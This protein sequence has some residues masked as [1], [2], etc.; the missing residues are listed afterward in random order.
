MTYLQ[1][2][3]LENEI[4]KL[5]EQKKYLEE[6]VDVQIFDLNYPNTIFK[7][8][9]IRRIADIIELKRLFFNKVKMQGMH[10]LYTGFLSLQ[11]RK[12]IAKIRENEHSAYLPEFN[13]DYSKI[14]FRKSS[15]V[16]KEEYLKNTDFINDVLPNGGIIYVLSYKGAKFINSINN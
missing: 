3:N 5:N 13:N 1:Y 15:P 7:T 14:V 12:N 4:K 9:S 8:I 16:E 11:E 10:M 2:T 6:Y